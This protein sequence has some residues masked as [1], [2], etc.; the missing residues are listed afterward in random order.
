MLQQSLDFVGMARFDSKSCA[1]Q[2]VA[3]HP[4]ARHA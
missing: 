1:I 2:N 3:L 4:L